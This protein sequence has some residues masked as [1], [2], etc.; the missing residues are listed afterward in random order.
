MTHEAAMTH[1]IISKPKAIKI[2]DSIETYFHARFRNDD[3]YR[4]Y[5][6]D[7]FQ[8][9]L[10]EINPD[11]VVLNVGAILEREGQY[12][13]LIDV[14]NLLTRDGHYSD[15]EFARIF[16]INCHRVYSDVEAMDWF[17]ALFAECPV[18]SSHFLLNE[19]APLP[20]P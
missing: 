19:F 4:I 2:I 12:T 13:M 3:Q 20:A 5:R 15:I 17:E 8:C 14:N 1:P 18:F 7:K 6:I 11:H 16:K 10:C 9:F